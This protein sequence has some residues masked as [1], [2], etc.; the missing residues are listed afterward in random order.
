MAL[1]ALDRVSMHYGGP[2]LL[3]GVTLE[4]HPGARIGIVG[5]NGSGKST[6]LNLLASALEPVQGLVTRARGARIAMQE[7][8]PKGA[9][10]GIPV[11]E[12]M[13]G[14]FGDATARERRLGVLAERIAVS[15]EP[16]ERA[17]LLEDY[18]RLQREHEHGGGYDV[19]RR[20][21]TVLSHLG[22]P[23]AA[24][25]RPFESFS[26]GERSVLG[27]ARVLLAEPDVLL[28]DE[29]SNHLDMEGVE[30]FIEFLAEHPGAVVMVSHNRHLLDASVDSIWEVGGGRVTVWTGSYADYVRQKEQA[31]ALQERQFEVQ[32]RLI[33][34]IEF[35]ARRLNDM[36]NAYDDPGQARRARSMLKRL[37][38]LDKV[39]RPDAGQRRFH[40][41][42]QGGGTAG[43]IAL[44]VKDLT[45]TR[46][47]RTLFEHA[48]VELE[49]GERVA[50]VGPNGSGKTSLLRAVLE[51][52][53]W[54]NPTLRLGKSVVLG[55]YRQFHDAFDPAL[56]VQEWLWRETKM[57][58]RDT[59]AVLHRFLFT[60]EDLARP[61]GTLSG[62]EKSR[63]QLARLVTSKISFLI[64]DEPTNHLDIPSCEQ[65][66]EMLEEFDG[67]LLV[68][69]HDRYFLDRLVTR[70]IEVENRG[71]V[72]HPMGFTEWWRAKRD[73]GRRRR[74]ALAEHG[75]LGGATLPGGGSAT[76]AATK[77]REREQRKR[78]SRL[79]AVEK[80]I[81]QLEARQSEALRALEAAATA[82]Y[83]RERMQRLETDYADA[84][85]RL[86]ALYAEWEA[87]AAALEGA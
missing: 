55:E 42:L 71:L 35:Q 86:A 39:E 81:T 79:Q 23:A 37:E 26:G 9:R 15:V 25:D 56:P 22:V 18:A 82:S 38:R 2:V 68:V 50:L 54:D 51:Q 73:A 16:H 11:R 80:D 6:L 57:D 27:L 43:R 45:L 60:R 66:E 69:S 76:I 44:S 52:G 83:D 46:G 21:E 65:L 61:I 85:A 40:A 36:A 48:S 75:P 12:E 20:I 13:R 70:V 59:A 5:P 28:L 4:V 3:D 87:L 62:G 14:V 74:R 29:P 34:R 67:T 64:L 58:D 10:P 32:Q 41:N 8:E 63:L 72:S 78:R 49:Q 24:W 53:S 19:E 31:R 17:G 1:L 30:W 47:D 84:R 77:E 33:R 7:Q